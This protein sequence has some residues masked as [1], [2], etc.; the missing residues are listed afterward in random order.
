V[1]KHRTNLMNRRKELN[2]T[3]EQVAKKAKITRA[4]YTNIEAGRKEPS[5]ST[6]KKIADSLKTTVDNIFFEN[7]VPNR[8]KNKAV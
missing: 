3:H 7:N 4:Y 2:L 6:A 5:M 8:N 1:N